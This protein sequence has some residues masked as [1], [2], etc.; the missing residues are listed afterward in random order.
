M[1]GLKSNALLFV[2]FLGACGGGDDRAAAPDSRNEAPA[3]GA[4]INLSDIDVPKPT[5]PFSGSCEYVG[6]SRCVE[7]YS[8]ITVGRAEEVCK[9]KSGVVFSSSSLCSRE[10]ASA[11]CYSNANGVESLEIVIYNSAEPKEEND[12]RKKA[13]NLSCALINGQ[14]VEIINAR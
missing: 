12:L 13:L 11:Y 14:F 8:G 1:L 4:G 10:N 3:A 6:M 7:Y 9:L 5:T 2:L